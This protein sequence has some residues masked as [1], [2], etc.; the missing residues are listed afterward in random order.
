MLRSAGASTVQDGERSGS[1][2]GDVSD[3]HVGERMPSTIPRIT[4]FIG[5]KRH[6]PGGKHGIVLTTLSFCIE[7]FVTVVFRLFWDG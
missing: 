7:I 5:G 1:L 3:I 6:I 4:I 2:E